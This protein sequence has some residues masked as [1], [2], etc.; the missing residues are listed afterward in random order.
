VSPIACALNGSRPAQSDVSTSNG[1]L[2]SSACHLLPGKTVN[3]HTAFMTNLHGSDVHTRSDTLHS[4]ESVRIVPRQMHLLIEPPPI[5]ARCAENQLNAIPFTE[6]WL[7]ERQRAGAAD[8][9]LSCMASPGPRP[10]SS[11]SLRNRQTGRPFRSDRVTATPG[12]GVIFR[13]AV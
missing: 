8:I 10:C 13:V 2:H 9:C 6:S 7:R 3:Q 5:P 1:V 11:R 12:E 4:A